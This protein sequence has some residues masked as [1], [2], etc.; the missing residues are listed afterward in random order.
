M[1]KYISILALSAALTATGAA[2]Q[3]KLTISVYSFA[4]D[5]Y[6]EALYDPFEEICGC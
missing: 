5:A 2:A 3:E 4:Q 6:K 1:T